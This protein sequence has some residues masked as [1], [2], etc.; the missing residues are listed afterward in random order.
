[1]RQSKPFLIFSFVLKLEDPWL[2]K[3]FFVSKFNFFV[4]ELMPKL[5]Q[6]LPFQIELYGNS[7]GTYKGSYEV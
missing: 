2:R 3:E 5:F 1:M 6:L 4:T 7:K